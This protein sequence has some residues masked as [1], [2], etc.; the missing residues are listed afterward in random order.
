MLA[1][2][3][4]KDET[5]QFKVPSPVPSRGADWGV[6]VDFSRGWAAAGQEQTQLP[7][8]QD[9]HMETQANKGSAMLVG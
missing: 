8:V 9:K 1:Q 2:A 3:L 4:R 5:G 7:T 6:A